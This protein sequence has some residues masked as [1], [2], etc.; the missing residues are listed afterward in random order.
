MQQKFKHQAFQTAVD[1]VADLFTGQEKQCHQFTISG[2]T[3]QAAL[4]Q[5]DFGS[6]NALLYVDVVAADFIAKTDARREKSLVRTLST[7]VS[8]S[9]S[10]KYEKFRG[11]MER[12][13]KRH[14]ASVHDIRYDPP[15]KT[16]FFEQFDGRW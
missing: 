6:G 16:Y 13:A 4:F 1:V 14:N 3:R 11:A 9:T 7:L 5:N 15:D 8:F 10:E 2:E 12:G